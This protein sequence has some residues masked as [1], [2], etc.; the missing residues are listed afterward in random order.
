MFSAAGEPCL[1][2]GMLVCKAVAAGGISVNGAVLEMYQER[3][4]KWVAVEEQEYFPMG[5][6]LY[7][8]KG[9]KQYIKFLL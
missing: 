4:A 6:K 3:D 9:Q 2:E 5:S 7:R 1:S 8:L